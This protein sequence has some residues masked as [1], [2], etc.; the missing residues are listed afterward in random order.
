MK[1]TF[2]FLALVVALGFS[3]CTTNPAAS[4]VVTLTPCCATG[5]PDKLVVLEDS[6]AQGGEV[7]RLTP[8]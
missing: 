6:F 8:H 7:V 2:A 1:L 5:G 3:A 4:K